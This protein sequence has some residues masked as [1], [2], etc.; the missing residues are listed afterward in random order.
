[1]EAALIAAE[2]RAA[3][4]FDGA[5]EELEELLVAG[6]DSAEFSEEEFW[7]PVDQKTNALLAEHKGSP[8]SCHSFPQGRQAHRV[9]IAAPS[10]HR[11]CLSRSE[12]ETLQLAFLA[13][14]GIRVHPDI[15]SR[16]RIPC[17]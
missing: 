7:S 11:P 1:M 13:D 8:G 12:S 5:E 9:I 16:N 15:T 3:P 17:A 14:S 4:S 10:S 2:Q 6:M